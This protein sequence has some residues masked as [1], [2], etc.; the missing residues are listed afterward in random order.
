MPLLRLS[1]G[2]PGLLRLQRAARPL[3]SHDVM[4]C[5]RT[6]AAQAP[7]GLR[8]RG[9]RVLWGIYMSERLG[10]GVSGEDRTVSQNISV[11]SRSLVV[12]ARAARE[13]TL[14][15]ALTRMRL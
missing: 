5:M 4:G 8:L 2:P 10:R 15:A 11:R 13:G 6:P 12:G 9:A 14:P 7:S 3:A 1:G